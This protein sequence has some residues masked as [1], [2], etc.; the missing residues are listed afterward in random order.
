[1]NIIPNTAFTPAESSLNWDLAETVDYVIPAKVT[2]ITWVKDGITKH[3][4]NAELKAGRFVLPVIN[5]QDIPADTVG[6]T[7]VLTVTCP[8][9]PTG[10]VAVR[11][12]IRLNETCTFK[13][14][15]V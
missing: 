10:F 15:A 3:A 6:K 14:F 11:D 12:T 7:G 2:H 4:F 13:S 9:T 8:R 1:M 5:P